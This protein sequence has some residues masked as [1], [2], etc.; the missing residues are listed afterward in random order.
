M[1]ILSIRSPHFVRASVTALL[2]FFLIASP[3]LSASAQDGSGSVASKKPTVTSK[4]S[5][6]KENLEREATQ[7]YRASLT[8][9]KIKSDQNGPTIVMRPVHQDVSAPLDEL[10]NNKKSF[11]TE[12]PRPMKDG[13]REIFEVDDPYPVSPGPLVESFLQTETLAPSAL[14]PGVSFE[15]PGGGIAGYTITSIPPDNTMAVGPNH[16]VAW[17]NSHIMIFNKTGVPQLP[18]PGFINGNTLWAGFGGSCETTNRGDPLVQYDRL[19]DRWIFS[20]FAFAV[21]GAGNPITPYLQCFA[22]STGSNPAGPYNRYAYSFDTAGA[23]GTPSF[24]DFG[25]IGIWNDAY[26]VAY[27]MFGGSPAGANTGAALCAYDKVL[28]LA[29]GAATSLCSPVTFYAGGASFLP[30]D[31][32][33]NTPPTDLTRG[34]LF[35]RQSTAP[36][37][38]IIRLKPNFA[39]STVTITDGYGGAVGSF[40]NLPIAITR[41]CNGG[42]GTCIPQPGTANVLD[43]LGDRLMY[44]LSYRNRFGTDSLVVCMAEDPDGVGAQQ[45]TMRWWE[46]RNPLGNP[47]VPATAPF[48]YQSGT[49]NPDATNRWMGSAAMNGD[50]DIMMAYNVSSGTVFPGIRITGRRVGDPIN[51]LQAEQVVIAGGG[52]Q[53][54]FTRWGDYSSLQVD[55]SDDRTFWFIGEYYSATSSFTWRTRIV[56]YVFPA[57]TAASVSVSGRVTTPDGR[58]L[59]NAVVTMAD[60]QGTTRSART[61]SFGNFRFDNVA[62][63]GTYILTV[64]AKLYQFQPRVVSVVDEMTG[65]DFVA[66]SGP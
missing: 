27:N 2:A 43:T 55:P 10:I 52:S 39:L 17:V 32:E 38:R 31:L 18:A 20:Q 65:V 16:V 9:K 61:S 6:A 56:S 33:G 45:A 40:I 24:N 64:Q 3:L 47:A 22:I 13:R 21:N 51:Q 8:P 53:T 1:P 14:L 57:P 62:A 36:A 29:G 11:T 35:L 25:K 44:R 34:G 37:L 54:G 15:G 19:A 66:V 50:G 60:S 30:A 63:G 46:I 59:R 7:K 12:A 48:I 28:M 23:G 4:E 42:G 58:G 49:F 41:P 26:Y 5:L